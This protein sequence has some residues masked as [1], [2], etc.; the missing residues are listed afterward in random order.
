MGVSLKVW[1]AVTDEMQCLAGIEAR[2]LREP[3]QQVSL[4]DPD[5][6][7][8]ARSGHGSGVVGYNVQVAVETEHHLI[9]AHEVTNVGSDRSQL[10]RHGEGSQG[11]YPSGAA[12]CRRRPRLFPQR[13][14]SG[15]RAGGAKAEGRFGKQDFVYQPEEDVYHCPVGETLK[16]HYTNVKNGLM[17]PRCWTTACHTCSIQRQC[18]PAKQ[19]P[20][21]PDRSMSTSSRQCSAGS[22][23]TRRRCA[24]G[25]RW[26]STPSAR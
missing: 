20:G 11:R 23:R 16:Y 25:A 9:V 8:M 6:R 7:S 15:L 10:A 19:R 26:S 3:H 13:G 24:S 4:T 12:R 17:L 21:S 2:M 1:I 5:A 14:G 18:T 22:T